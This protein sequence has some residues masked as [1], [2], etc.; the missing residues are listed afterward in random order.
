MR[1]SVG[2]MIDKMLTYD[3][4]LKKHNYIRDGYGI[5]TWSH[6]FTNGENSIDIRHTEWTFYDNLNEVM[7]GK[8]PDSLDKFLDIER[9]KQLNE[10]K[11]K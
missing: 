6:R 5:K 8:D 1:I 11:G 4:I 7:V 3:E 10:S 2:D 9:E